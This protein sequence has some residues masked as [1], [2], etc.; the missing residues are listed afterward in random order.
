[1]VSDYQP[2]GD[3]PQAIAKLVQGLR[4]EKPH[5]VLLG[6]TGSGKTFTM[7]NIIEKIQKPTLVI[8]HNKTLAA[9]L[10]Q[11]FR[12]YF[13]ENSVE[14]F[15]SYYDYYQ[16][17]AYV[18]KRDL[19]ISKEA[20][21]NE[22][23]D[24]LRLA[25]TTS[26]LTRPDVIVVASVSCI[27]NLGSPLEYGKAILPLDL[28]IP[29]SREE[30]LS[31]LVEL[32]YER[33]DYDFHR[34]SFRVRGE[35]VDLWPSYTDQ[36]LRMIFNG[37]GSLTGLE[38]IQVVTGESLEKLDTAVIYPAKHY[39]ADSTRYE[40]ALKEI[41]LEL[42]ARLKELRKDGK[43]VEAQRLK[44]RTQYD[45]EMLRGTGYCSG[46]ENYSRY[47]DGREKGDPPYSLLDYFPKDYLVF[48]DESHITVPQIRGMYNGDFARKKTLIDY[49]FRLP[50]AS[51][52]RPLRF[53][54][55]LQRISRVIYFSATPEEWEISMSNG[56]MAEQLV[57][58]TGLLDPIIAIRKTAGQIPDL[59][60][61]I[62]KRVAR[63]ERVLV[64][65]LTKKL[66]EDLSIYLKERGI[67]VHHL[68]ADIPTM[69]RS[70]ILDSLRQGEFD[71][72]VGINLL[73]EGLDLPE[74]SLVAILDAD[75]EGFLRSRTS[76]IQTMGRASRHV[77]G[78]VILYA[79]TVTGSMQRAIT[80]VDRRRQIQTAW[81]KKYH[82][83]PV[84]IT[85]P[86]RGRLIEKTVKENNL[87]IKLP[88]EEFVKMS[89]QEQ[90]GAI[91]LLEKEMKL[92]SEIL[93]FETA[94][95]YRD[96]IKALRKIL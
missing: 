5:Q 39:I 11:E 74:V 24:K 94:A 64:T 52:N 43:I 80:E 96:Q 3:Q 83:T 28:K 7:A 35:A 45:L 42:A 92:A 19:Y 84:G 16:P 67:K 75:K 13:P 22:E 82:I 34:S 10:T 85:K 31:R 1:M 21:I 79:D 53:T 25:A 55:F 50:S 27:Y 32:Y 61:E 62:E 57:R 68:H 76:L 66:A 51:D 72:I 88:S 56:E 70:D 89:P 86:L 65:T 49:G 81:N 26:L 77:N 78:Q 54:E 59:L 6:V 30:V 12:E 15:V 33:S 9:Q 63:Q 29:K 48:I 90:S 46:I 2:A 17:E 71:V 58:P 47:F 95:Y 20:D 93:D 14:Y 40:K 18:P 23:I 91:K 36:G 8:S 44:E 41:K 60:T 87:A 37:V 73:R 4:D 69:E 38:K